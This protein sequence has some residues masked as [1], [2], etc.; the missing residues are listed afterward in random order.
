MRGSWGVGALAVLTPLGLPP[1][2]DG[3]STTMSTASSSP[4]V[5]AATSYSVSKAPPS[6]ERRL[7]SRLAAVAR[8]SG[9]CAK[10]GVA[11][12]PEAL[13]S[14]RVSMPP[15]CHVRGQA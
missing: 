11:P 8:R 3:V 9:L 15:S 12:F 14:C 1:S 13:L 6:S 2:G 7:S 4:S 5:S 10:W